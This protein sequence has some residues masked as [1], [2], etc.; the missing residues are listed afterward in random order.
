MF[1]EWHFLYL[2]EPET[3]NEKG[4]Y[5]VA[6]VKEG[7]IIKKTIDDY[8]YFDERTRRIYAHPFLEDKP[9][10]HILLKTWAKM[11][12]GYENILAPSPFQFAKAFTFPDWGVFNP[13]L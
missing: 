1:P 12:K 13:S 8:V 9:W 6:V 5:H 2:I 7:R 3:V 10:T 4:Y 11:N